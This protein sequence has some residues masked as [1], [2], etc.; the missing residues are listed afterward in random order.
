MGITKTDHGKYVIKN[1]ISTD[2]PGKY[3]IAS[4]QGHKYI[5]LL[6]NHGT[7]YKHTCPIKSRKAED[8]I[9]G[10]STYYAELK[11]NG[12]T[13]T[14]LKLDNEI[15]KLFVTYID[16]AEKIDYQ[17]VPVGNCRT[18]MA[19]HAIKKKSKTTSSV[20]SVA[21]TQIFQPTAGIY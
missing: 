11:V 12:F 15:S 17:Q 13:A 5:F 16:E 9:I 10:F 1:L 2:L 3:P 19:E 7:N 21:L 14:N 18:L 20:Y 8:L 6:Y 4:A